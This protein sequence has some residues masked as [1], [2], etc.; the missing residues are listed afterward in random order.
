MFLFQEKCN[1][2]LSPEHLCVLCVYQ[3]VLGSKHKETQ[4]M[5]MSGE[6]Q[7]LQWCLDIDPFSL[8]QPAVIIGRLFPAINSSQGSSL[9]GLSMDGF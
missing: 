1:K 4:L 5:M 2:A 6:G 8:R 9:A 7:S 3:D